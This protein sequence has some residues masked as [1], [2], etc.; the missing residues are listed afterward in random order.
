MSRRWGRWR[1]GRL[2]A[3]LVKTFQKRKENGVFAEGLETPRSGVTDEERVLKTVFLKAPRSIHYGEVAK[4]IDGIKGAGAS[5]IGLQ[6][7]DLD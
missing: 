4:V 1:T 7:D 6:I 5:P 2:S 3:E